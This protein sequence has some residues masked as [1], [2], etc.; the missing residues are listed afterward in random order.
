M[1]LNRLNEMETYILQCS[2]VSLEA[3][4][5]HFSISINTVRRDIAEILKKGT[6]KKVYGGV[7]AVDPHKFAALSAHNESNVS[8]KQVIGAQAATLI[9]DEYTIFLDA[10]TTAV[11][12]IP[13]LEKKKNIT[14]VTNSLRIINET[15]K[16]PQL[17]LLVMGGY[18]DDT[19]HAFAGTR[20]L[21]SL[22]N[23]DYDLVFIGTSG[24]S[25]TRGLTTDPFFEESIKRHLIESNP[26]KVVLL[27]DNT[28]FDR[29]ALLTFGKLDDVA[30]VITEKRPPEKYLEMMEAS[31]T[32]FLWPE[33]AN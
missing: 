32:I 14:I 15:V 8:V 24:I 31:G 11:Q 5:S 33:N 7:M 20:T 26:G 27:A 6:I 4:A 19:T 1:R 17:N 30:Y 29:S 16:Y 2:N 12:I 13:F 10:G 23:V 18:Y 22:N 3:L 28:K 21:Q 9:K 25:P